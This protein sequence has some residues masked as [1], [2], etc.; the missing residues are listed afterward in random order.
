M[1]KAVAGVATPVDPSPPGQR[2]AQV[3][4]S[5]LCVRFAGTGRGRRAT[6]GA[7]AV[8]GVSFTVAPGEFV[9][10]VG[11]SG[12]GKST[13]LKVSAGLLRPSRGEVRITEAGSDDPRVGFV[14]QSDALLPWRTALQNVELAVRLSGRAGDPA[15]D[16]GGD[17]A[18]DTVGGTARQLM[19][20]LG[21]AD[22]GEKY[23]SQLSGGMR[24][25]VALARAI[26]YRPSVFLM[27][28]PFGALDAQTRIRVGNFCLGIFD[29]LKQSVL[30]VTHDIEEAVALAD[31]VL[32][33]SSRPA[34]VVA[35]FDVP[36]AR[37]RD[38]HG[39]RYVDGFKELQ[40]QVW[41]ALEGG[42]DHDHQ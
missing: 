34:R 38:Y 20:D 27:D 32:V 15:G 35:S 30:F 37:P 16:T 28:E 5:D 10:V 40:Q 14:F 29:R 21:L 18:G 41:D 31:R 9:A 36:F 23:P 1:T 7:L 13:I 4:V 39:S 26:A 3:T 11:P 12:C 2:G 19:A 42:S 8:D 17:A 33:L 24:K 25:R 6:A 22:A